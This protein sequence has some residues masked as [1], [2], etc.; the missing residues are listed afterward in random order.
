MQMIKG[1]FE[2]ESYTSKFPAIQLIPTIYPSLSAQNQAEAMNIFIKAAADDIP[3][4]RKQV[5]IV[6]N[7][8]IKMIPKVPDTELLNVF[9]KLNKDE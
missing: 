2:N 7:D 6:L 1:L 9:S 5:A 8:L 4:V 3:L